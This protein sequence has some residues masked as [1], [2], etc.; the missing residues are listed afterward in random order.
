MPSNGATLFE[1]EVGSFYR[2]IQIKQA[3]LDPYANKKV[4]CAINKNNNLD[5]ISDWLA[6][7]SYYQGVNAVL[8]VDNSSDIY[9]LQ[10]LESTLS[11]VPGVDVVGVVHAPF[12]FGPIRGVESGHGR[13]KFFQPAMLNLIKSKFLSYA[14]GVLSVDID[15]LLVSNKED[16]IFDE[17]ER[18]FFGFVSFGGGWRYPIDGAGKRHTD[19]VLERSHDSPCP[20]KYCYRPGYSLPSFFS[21]GVHGLNEIS[22]KIMPRSKN[23]SFIHCWE[24]STNWKAPRFTRPCGDSF[25][26]DDHVKT[27][28]ERFRYREEYEKTFESLN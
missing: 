19:H 26:V 21:L 8:I 7:H 9:S 17:L 27:L 23:F 2:S 1:F 11:D 4:L 14:R 24:I 3:D 20:P 18:G 25:S 12:P 22:W 5:W 28:F 15:E 16:T 13:A 6:W 10:A